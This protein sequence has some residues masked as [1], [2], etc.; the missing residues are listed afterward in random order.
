LSPS[1]VSATAAGAMTSL[2]SRVRAYQ[3]PS[4]LSAGSPAGFVMPAAQVAE[5]LPLIAKIL[6]HI[7]WRE[8]LSVST[9]RPTP[10]SLPL[11]TQS[12]L[13]RLD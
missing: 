4:S 10:D 6:S 5:D 9:P 12:H 7:G 8:A 1:P 13:I 3:T 2:S 11:A